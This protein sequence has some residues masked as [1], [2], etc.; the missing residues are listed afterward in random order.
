MHTAAAFAGECAAAAH[1]YGAAIAAHRA[2][3]SAPKRDTFC[4]KCGF[5]SS[6][7]R[8]ESS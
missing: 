2:A 3:M 5:F 4:Q 8:A 1:P 7:N 6:V